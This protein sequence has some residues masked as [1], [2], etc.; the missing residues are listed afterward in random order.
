MTIKSAIWIATVLSLTAANVA[1]A[2]E[3][4]RPRTVHAP[5]A[6]GPIAI[7]DARANSSVEDANQ[8][9]GGFP[10]LIVF[11]IVAAGLGLYFA[12]DDNGDDAPTSPP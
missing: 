12:V 8:Q 5:R 10:F 1:S 9:V 7:P 3:P 6:L 4:V 2:V 11:V